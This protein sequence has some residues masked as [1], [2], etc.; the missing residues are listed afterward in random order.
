MVNFEKN[1]ILWQIFLWWGSW[2]IISFFLGNGYQHFNQFLIRA[3]PNILAFAMV[4]I[5]NIKFLL[6]K[7][8][9]KKKIFAFICMGI[10]LLILASFLVY[11]C[12]YPLLEG[13]DLIDGPRGKPAINRPRPPTGI[14]W[15]GRF[16]PFIITFLGSTIIEIVRFANRKEK[17]TIRLEKERLNSELKFLKS[18][19]NPHF[20]FNA[21]NNIY[22]LS[23]IQAPQTPESIMQLSEI[24]RYMVYDSNE[25]KV[26][27]KSEINYINNFVDL[28][29]LKDSRGMNVE[30]NL[31]EPTQ[32]ILIAPLL[33][34]PFVENAFKHSKVENL[35]KGYIRISLIS[36]HQWIEFKV[37]NSLPTESFTK[38]EVGGV[39]LENTRKRL[40]LL[41]PD[42]HHELEIKQTDDAFKV[43]LKIATS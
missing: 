35:K 40:Q 36:N 32:K 3:I 27:L 6:P 39:G 37:D 31:E 28:K 26:P 9:F 42:G 4:V 5:I 18:Q 1:N 41:Y 23:V 2:H 30:L 15:I 10:V 17:E 21:L 22:S 14:K 11:G 20:L 33:F 25:E 29:K 12:F 43:R 8:F 19:V 16:T 13:L 34:I 7:L 24:L 38:D